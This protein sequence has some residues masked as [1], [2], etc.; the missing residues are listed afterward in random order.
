M[1]HAHAS[2]KHF[3]IFSEADGYRLIFLVHNLVLHKKLLSIA[4]LI[5]VLIAIYF[6]H[7]GDRYADRLTYH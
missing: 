6:R 1:D 5:Q 3:N 7:L 4:Q 2:Y